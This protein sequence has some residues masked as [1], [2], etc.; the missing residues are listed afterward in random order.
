[1]TVQTLAAL[2]HDVKDIRRTPKE[3]LPDDDLWGMTRRE[4]RLLITTDKGFTRRRYEPHYGLLIV[5][6][7][8]PTARKIH[9]AILQVLA[10]INPEH[11]PGTI[12]V[13]RDR[14]KSTWHTNLSQSFHT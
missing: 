12:V 9:D 6:L 2:R 1:M 8:Q 13:I 14:T 11:W 3:G 4:K 5:R 10:E 7:R